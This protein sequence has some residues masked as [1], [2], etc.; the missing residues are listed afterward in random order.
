MSTADVGRFV[1]IRNY[2]YVE[3]GVFSSMQW[4]EE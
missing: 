4:S 3:D 1:G 2:L